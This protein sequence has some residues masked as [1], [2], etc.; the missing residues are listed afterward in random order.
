LERDLS[1]FDPWLDANDPKSK[2]KNFEPK[3]VTLAFIRLALENA[4]L[5]GWNIE[6]KIKLA[7]LK[8]TDGVF[9]VRE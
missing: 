2:P 3:I 1:S 5:L 8:Y 9:K 7:K 6:A 4:I